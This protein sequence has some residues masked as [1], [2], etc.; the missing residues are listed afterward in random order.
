MRK[1]MCHNQWV[2]RKGQRNKVYKLHK[3]LWTQT[4]LKSLNKKIDGFLKYIGFMKCVIKYGVHVRR[5]NK[6]ELI[7]LC[8]YVDDLFITCSYKKEIEDFK[9]DLLKKFEMSDFGNISYFLGIKFY[10][11]GRGLM[12]HQKMYASEIL[13]RF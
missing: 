11:C 3:A 10:K 8:L 5:D 7:I 6:N 2:L 4:S 9:L 1:C 13:K 12:M